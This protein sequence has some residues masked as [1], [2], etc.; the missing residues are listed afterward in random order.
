MDQID[1]GRI[2]SRSPPDRPNVAETTRL[3]SLNV[4]LFRHSSWP[5][6]DRESSSLM[7]AAPE[8][9]RDVASA[10]AWRLLR[11]GSGWLALPLAAQG[12]IPISPLTGHQ[13]M[14]FTAMR[15]CWRSASVGT[16]QEPVARDGEAT[17]LANVSIE[18]AQALRGR[19]DVEAG[20]LTAT[21]RGYTSSAGISDDFHRVRDF[22]VHQRC[23]NATRI[24]APFPPISWVA[25]RGGGGT[26]RFCHRGRRAVAIRTA[27]AM[28]PSP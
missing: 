28:P 13:R 8:G 12:S 10:G 18:A 27:A 15:R 26:G 11:I 2:V 4:P 17:S 5:G 24:A 16:N 22:L 1:G 21:V 9:P 19:Q 7:G 14:G 6:D 25:S 20:Y 3:V 23:G